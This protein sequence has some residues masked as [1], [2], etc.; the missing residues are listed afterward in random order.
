MAATGWLFVVVIMVLAA[1]LIV[2]LVPPLL[3]AV[4]TYWRMRGTRLVTCPETESTVAVEVDAARAARDA[5]ARHPH[6]RL[7]DCT[8]WPERQDC[9]QG[10]VSQI[11]ADPEGC[12]VWRI[13][14]RWYED[15]ACV[16]CGRAIKA[17]EWLDFWLDHTPALLAADQETVKWT[18]LPPEALPDELRSGQPVCWSCHVA[19]RFR[20]DHPELVTE[21]PR[22]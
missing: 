5:A 4:R 16:Y 12:M 8:R 1:I 14:Q 7:R 11:E 21:R 15:K 22:N 18:D 6:V 2:V 19:E 13:V 9:P 3:T 10:C 20:R 17:D